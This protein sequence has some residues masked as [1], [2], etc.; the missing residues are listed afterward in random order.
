MKNFLLNI[1]YISLVFIIKTR[2]NI[3]LNFSFGLNLFLFL[4]GGALGFLLFYLN[5]FFYPFFAEK[6]DELSNKTKEYFETKNFLLGINFLMLNEE[7]MK[8]HVLKTALTIIAL[9]IS[10]YFVY[11]SS[12]SLFGAGVGYGLLF[13]LVLSMLKDMENP[14]KLNRWFEQIKKPIETQYQR[15]FVYA[16]IGLTILISL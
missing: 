9:I 3:S 6:D 5:Y 4:L 1:V 10:T 7:K 2:F 14:E 16:V 13:H 12:G 11:I 8:F 15:L